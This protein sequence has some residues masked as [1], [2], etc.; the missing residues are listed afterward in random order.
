MF[1]SSKET[2]KY[3]NMNLRKKQ[4]PIRQNSW[5]IFTQKSLIWKKVILSV[6]LLQMLRE[7]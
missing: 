2:H 7:I 5:L 1:W 3:K 4:E 6:F